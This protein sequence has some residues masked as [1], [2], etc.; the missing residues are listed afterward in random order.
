MNQS[1]AGTAIKKERS[2]RINHFH[3]GFSVF[4][5]SF[6]LIVTSPHTS[7]PIDAGYT[8]N[9]TGTISQPPPS[10]GSEFTKYVAHTL[11]SNAMSI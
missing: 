11:I 5:A 10:Q 8:M 6:M 4:V 9:I 7:I 3:H 1:K 2:L